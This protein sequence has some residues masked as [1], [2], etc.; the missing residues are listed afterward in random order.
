MQISLSYDS[1]IITVMI[2]D[3]LEGK[4]NKRSMV[5]SYLFLE[6]L[7]IISVFSKQEFINNEASDTKSFQK[8]DGWTVAES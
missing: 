5:I 3:P 2:Q 4:E 7:Q 8:H 1:K 6:F